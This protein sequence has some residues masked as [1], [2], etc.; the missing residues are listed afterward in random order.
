MLIAGGDIGGLLT[1]VVPLAT[2]TNSTASA[3]IYE[4]LTDTFGLVG[5]LNTARE[6]SATAVVLPNGK[7]L[8]VG[9]SHCAPKPT[10]QAVSAER[11]RSMASS[12]T[13][14]TQQSCTVR[15][16]ARPA[17]SPWRALAAAAI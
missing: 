15:P 13:R 5:S 7:T 8:I 4:A 16:R 10:A 2:S 3:E 6:A 1:G 14:S 9:G 12:A 17:A 11:H